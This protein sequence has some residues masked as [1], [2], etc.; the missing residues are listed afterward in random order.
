MFLL[1]C[2][3]AQV[4]AP[5]GGHC[6]YF[7]VTPHRI[8]SAQTRKGHLIA[9]LPHRCLVLLSYKLLLAGSIDDPKEYRQHATHMQAGMITSNYQ[10]Y[11]HAQPLLRYK[12]LLAGIIDDPKERKL[13]TVDDD[14]EEP[15]LTVVEGDGASTSTGGSTTP[16][17]G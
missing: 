13:M 4:Q 5:A 1:L 14:Y 9:V 8:V 15:L 3:L 6:R 7:Q 11:G 2:S 16:Y 17:Q 10:H 12:L